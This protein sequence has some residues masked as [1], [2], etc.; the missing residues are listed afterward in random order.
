MEATLNI[1]LKSEQVLA[2]FQQLDSNE[3]ISIFEEFSDE[4]LMYLGLSKIE[5]L[6]FEQYNENL[7]QG[8]KDYKNGN[9]ISHKQMRNEISKWKNQKH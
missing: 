4:W 8:L 6:S 5:P 9:T 1:K 7:E 2:L 3:R